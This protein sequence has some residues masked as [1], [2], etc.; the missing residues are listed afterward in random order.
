[1]T[2]KRRAID[3]SALRDMSLYDALML[4]VKAAKKEERS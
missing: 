1:M 3:L 4:V 2:P